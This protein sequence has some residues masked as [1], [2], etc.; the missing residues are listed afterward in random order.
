[1]RGVEEVGTGAAV[2]RRRAHSEQA[3]G[4]GTPPGLA[5]AHAAGVPVRHLRGD[6]LLDEAP[7]LAAKELVVLGEDVASHSRAPVALSRV[8][9]AA[10]SGGPPRSPLIVASPSPMARSERVTACTASTPAR[11]AATEGSSSFASSPGP[12]ARATRLPSN[13]RAGG[14]CSR[15][16]GASAGS[17]RA[18]RTCRNAS[19]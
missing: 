18:D 1:D 14:N 2:V 8:S 7:H 5:V 15:W 3:F 4:A 13:P 16:I 17:P 10:A 9:P 12:T 6:L 11:T 19:G